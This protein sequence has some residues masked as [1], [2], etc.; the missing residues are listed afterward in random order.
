MTRRP[1][2]TATLVG[3]IIRTTQAAVLYRETVTDRET[4]I[5]RSV[6]Q[7]GDQVETGDT[8]LVCACWFIEKEDL[9]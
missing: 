3:E 6:L 7:D 1:P 8:D 4:W 5:P 9:T 2:R